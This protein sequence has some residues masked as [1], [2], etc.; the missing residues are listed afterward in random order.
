MNKKLSIYEKALNSIVDYTNNDVTA[1]LMKEYAIKGMYNLLSCLDHVGIQ[2]DYTR[3]FALPDFTFSRNDFRFKAFFPYG[4]IV[5]IDAKEPFIPVGFRPNC[6]GI[7]MLKLSSADVDIDKIKER[8]VTLVS[9]NHDVSTDDL[10]RGNHFIGLYKNLISDSFYAI[11]HGSFSFVKSGYKDIPGLYIDKTNYWDKEL[12]IDRINGVEFPYLIGDVAKTYFNAYIEYEKIT[13]EL[14][15]HISQHLFP[16]SRIIFNETHEGFYDMNTITLGSYICSHPFSAPIMLSAE[17][18][19]SIVNISR[20][21]SDMPYDIYAC[22]HGGGYAL[23]HIVTG[24][25][26]QDTQIYK[27]RFTN[28]S[29]TET[30]DIRK[31]IYDYRTNTDII[32]TEQH[33]FG[34]VESKYATIYNFKL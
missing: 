10:N 7:T 5:H 32:W 4:S 3:L 33:K 12:H 27:L 34:T 15:A 19:L 30:K 8:I 21:L 14:R 29:I 17:S 25:Y 20:P 28:D 2:G 6:C 11:I 16:N 9:N 24:M 13:K 31:L 1:H 18:D 23:T 22:P 26:D